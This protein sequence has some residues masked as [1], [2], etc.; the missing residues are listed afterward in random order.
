MIKTI[1]IDDEDNSLSNLEIL[2]QLYCPTLTIIGKYSQ[3]SQGLAA[4]ENEAPDLVFL[5]IEMPHMNGFELL[6]KAKARSFSVIFT[7]AFDKYAVK[8]IRYSA[9]DF[10][11]KPIDPT[12]L[13]KAVDRFQLLHAKTSPSFNQEQFQFLLDTLSAKE[14][15]LKKIAIANLEGF[16]LVHVDDIIYCEADDNYTHLILK[17]RH[18]LTASR[19]LKDIQSLFTEYPYF[20]RIHHSYLIN[21]HEVIQYNRGEGGHVVMSNGSELA[22]SRNKKDSLIKYL[23]K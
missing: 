10:L 5:D 16:R 13:M 22:V 8:A 17:N 12:E 11:V 21:L 4:I 23:M 15:T 7:T 20:F 2:V 1:L 19:T 18:K 14:H 6:E 9:L 3:S